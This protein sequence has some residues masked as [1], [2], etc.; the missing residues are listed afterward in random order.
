MG[1]LLAGALALAAD[2]DRDALEAASHR[3]I[4]AINAHDSHTAARL[5]TEDVELLDGW[6]RVSGRDAAI[7]KVGEIVTRGKLVA[8][9]REITIAGDV[10]W[11]V[12]ALAQVQKDG[13]VQAL[14]QALEIW[15]R[16]DDKWQ[17]HRRMAAGTGAPEG[18]LT[19][20]EISEPIL[21]RSKQ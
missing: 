6:A 2:S 11:R 14:G 19:R 20:P 21:D 16:V 3:W 9:S 13:D 17:L 10:A 8:T 1:G 5:M 12:V 7:R 18:L 15:K 4:R